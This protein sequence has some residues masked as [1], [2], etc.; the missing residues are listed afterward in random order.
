M[1]EKYV[2]FYQKLLEYLTF[3]HLKTIKTSKYKII[4]AKL[5]NMPDTASV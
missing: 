5:A 4:A 2:Q 3:W 1:Y